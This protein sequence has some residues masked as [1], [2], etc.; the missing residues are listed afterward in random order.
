LHGAVDLVG[1][2][3]TILAIAHEA[4]RDGRYD[5]SER[6]TLRDRALELRKLADSLIA[7]VEA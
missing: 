6:A 3:S 1:S 7:A 5:A 4:A 2:A